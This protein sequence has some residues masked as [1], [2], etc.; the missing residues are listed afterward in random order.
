MFVMKTLGILS[1][2]DSNIINTFELL[3]YSCIRCT[4]THTKLARKR[5]QKLFDN[6]KRLNP[7]QLE[8]YIP[9]TNRNITIRGKA[10]SKYLSSKYNC[11]LKSETKENV[12]NS[13][14]KTASSPNQMKLTLMR[15]DS[16][17]EAGLSVFWNVGSLD[18]INN[19]LAYKAIPVTVSKM[20]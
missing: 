8:V 2:L 11:N 9:W 12:H 13:K 17:N 4:I 16:S 1:T 10:K 3:L 18:P 15:K 5:E 6:Q 19:H 7:I 20:I 14:I